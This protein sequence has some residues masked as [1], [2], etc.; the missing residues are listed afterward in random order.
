MFFEIL[1]FLIFAVML[2]LP[3]IFWKAHKKDEEISQKISKL[4]SE[5]FDYQRQANK[6]I[7]QYRKSLNEFSR[8]YNDYQFEIKSLLSQNDRTTQLIASHTSHIAED[9]EKLFYELEIAEQSL[10]TDHSMQKKPDELITTIP[11]DSD[12]GRR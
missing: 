12:S 3:I 7:E 11:K 4:N 2:C 6:K 5:F 10:S 9:K 1:W 8:T